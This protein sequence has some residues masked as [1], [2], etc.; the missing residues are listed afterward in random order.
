LTSIPSGQMCSPCHSLRVSDLLVTVFSVV[1][2][3]ILSEVALLYFRTFRGLGQEKL[4]RRRK[5]LPRQRSKHTLTFWGKSADGRP[6][7]MRS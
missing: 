4:P 3:N 1:A 6:P 7:R 5:L 2:H